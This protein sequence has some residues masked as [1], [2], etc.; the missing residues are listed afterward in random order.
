MMKKVVLVILFL[1]LFP[2]AALAKD[3]CNNNDIK[4]ESITLEDTRGNLEEI[5]SATALEKTINLDLKMNVIGDSIEYKIILKNT[6]D[7]DYYFNDNDLYIDKSCIDYEVVCE[8]NSN[9]IKAGTEKTIFLKVAYKEKVELFNLENGVYNGNQSIILNLS[10]KNIIEEIIENPQTGRNLWFILL[11]ILVIGIILLHKKNK[12]SI[13]LLLTIMIIPFTVKALCRCSIG[14]NTKLTIDGKEAIFLPGKEANIKMKELAGD[15]TSTAT[16]GY[17]FQN[18]NITA[19]KNSEVEP[20]DYNKEEK[21]IVSIAASPYPIYMWYEEGTIYWW[22]EDKTPSLNEDASDMFYNFSVLNSII[23]L[24]NFDTSSVKNINYYFWRDKIT[25]ANALRKWATK[26]IENM[27]SV[28]GYNLELENIE[29]LENWDTSNVRD[30]TGLFHNT[31]K[32]LSVA[33]IKDWDVSEVENMSYMFS[34]AYSLEEIDLSNWHTKKL[35]NMA[36]MFASLYYSL[37]YSLTSALKRIY[38]SKNFDTSK[39]TNMQLLLYNDRYIEDYT[40]L[41]YIDGSSLLDIRQL[42]QD[43]LNLD[44]LSLTYIKDWN[45]SKVKSFYLLFIGCSS[46]TNLD[47]IKNWDTGNVEDMSRMFMN[48][49]ALTDVSAIENWDTSNVV[50]MSEMFYACPNLSNLN[51]SKWNTSNVTNM[52]KMFFKCS[53]LSNLNLKNWDTSKVTNMSY[54][55]KNCEKLTSLDLST[56]DTSN[57]TDM[58][59]MFNVMSNLEELDISGFNTKKVTTFTR[60]FNGSTKLKHIYI[61]EAWD[62]EANTGE[63][64][65]IFPTT[66]ELPNFSSSNP[67]YRS[68]SYAHAGEGGYLTLKTE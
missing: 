5:N 44:S 32:L 12:K 34:C 21:N 38:L 6:S 43:N 36:Y 51:L 53:N 49:T 58:S 3:I 56:W 4:I 52:Y 10:N 48:A 14:I 54:M 7:E 50:N 1:L 24:E 46:L 33:A 62:T 13:L 47:G 35:K 26:K 64:K 29:G 66:C 28:F 63:V 15:D 2:S 42:F 59:Y 8:D 18:K 57:V 25:E 61:G 55:F 67:N 45:V 17:N 41:K 16:N 19:I 37:D 22:S 11:I 23:G 30:M 9:L 20:I 68:L 39:V 65:Y 40:F 31:H 60:I 27:I